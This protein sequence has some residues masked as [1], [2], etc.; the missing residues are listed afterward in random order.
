MNSTG[1]ATRALG[2]RYFALFVNRLAYTRQSHRPAPNG[3]HYYYRPTENRSL[4]VDTVREHLIGRLTIGL[5][6]LN[7]ESQRSKWV[8]IDADY[9]GALDDLLK[10][11]WELRQDG[12]EAA[13]EKSRRGAH[14]WVFAQQPLLASHCRIYIYNLARRLKVPVKGGAGLAD[15]IEVF[16]RQDRLA[17]DEFGNAI[18]GPLGVHRGAGRRYWFY[19]A[20]YSLASQLAYLERLK[21][22]TE[23]ELLRFIDGLEM[24]PEFQPRSK[25]TLPPYDPNRQEFRILDFVQARRRCAGNYWT[26]CPSCAE[27]GRDRSADN[28]AI[29]V[30][31]P[32]KYRC[33]AGCTK[34]MI[35]AALGQPIRAGRAA[36]THDIKQRYSKLGT[37]ANPRSAGFTPASNNAETHSRRRNLLRTLDLD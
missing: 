13:L 35:R 28:L 2:S 4:T 18:R 34:E 16:P 19:G 11:Q 10:L 15:G 1:Q 7:P 22:I 25:V 9:A 26:R 17:P 5:Y 33:W 8:A 27:Q 14:L 21:K 30:A 29:S 12:V 32:R 23:A 31:D 36:Y 20:D 37:S 24:P 6:A 3:K